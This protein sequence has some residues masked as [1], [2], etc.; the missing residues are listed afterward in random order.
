[1]VKVLDFGISKVLHATPTKDHGL[2]ST[3][4]LMGSPSY[5]SPEQIRSAKHVDTRT[6]IWALGVV[7]Y[8]LLTARPPFDGDNVATL[9]TQICM[10][11]P[12][13]IAA[14]AMPQGLASVVMRCLEKAPDARYQTLSELAR[15]LAPFAPP[16]ARHFAERIARLSPPSGHDLTLPASAASASQVDRPFA[17][18]DTVAATASTLPASTAS[19]RKKRIATGAALVVVALGGTFAWWRLATKPETPAPTTAEHAPS[20]QE[21]TAHATAP[22]VRL[23]ASAAVR[24][25]PAMSGSVERPSPPAQRAI[26]IAKRL[27]SKPAT[28]KC[29][30]GQVLSQGHCCPIGMVW[31]KS[32]CERPLAKEVP[33]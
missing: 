32:G 24:S 33:F 27:P 18:A 9:S 29:A 8:E 12:A 30:A 26:P 16:A 10:D 15:A 28:S 14:L 3:D 13:P 6:D 2:T 1:L 20:S 22:V 19:T 11:A 5:M 4:M 7:L 17:A 25:A 23:A 21:R 31:G